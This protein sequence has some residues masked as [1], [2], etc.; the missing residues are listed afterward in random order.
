MF[1]RVRYGKLTL[2]QANKSLSSG[3]CS[4]MYV[5]KGLDACPSRVEKYKVQKLLLL[6]GMLVVHDS[7]TTSVTRSAPSRSGTNCQDLALA[8]C[9]PAP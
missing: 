7:L 3:Q 4:I 6:N 1:T 8:K 5:E 2:A 9:F